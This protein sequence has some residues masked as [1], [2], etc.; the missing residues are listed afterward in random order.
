MGIYNK[1]VPARLV[2]KIFIYKQIIEYYTTSANDS[3]IQIHDFFTDIKYNYSV[4]RKMR[5]VQM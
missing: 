1:K 5:S 3:N 2:K 4:S